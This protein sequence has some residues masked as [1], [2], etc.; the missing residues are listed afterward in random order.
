MPALP[1]ALPEPPEPP[2]TLVPDVLNDVTLT[3]ALLDGFNVVNVVTAVGVPAAP[4]PAP[5]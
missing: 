3:T 4:A 2:A 5:P 1:P